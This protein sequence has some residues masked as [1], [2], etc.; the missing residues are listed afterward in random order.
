MIRLLGLVVSLSLSLAFNSA[1]LAKEKDE[2]ASA[3]DRDVKIEKTILCRKV[4][5]TFEP[6]KSFKPNDTFALVVYLSEAKVGMRVRAAWTLVHAGRLENIKLLEKKM[7]LTEDAIKSVKEPNRFNFGLEHD[8][9]YRPGDYKIE[10]YV[11]DELVKT[12]E[13]QVK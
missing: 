7:E 1:L 9:P 4:E 11:N 8:D 6:A 3:S 12:V 13:F 5:H 10:I 2:H